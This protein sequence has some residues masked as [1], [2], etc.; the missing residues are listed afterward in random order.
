MIAQIDPEVWLGR[1]KRLDVLREIFIMNIIFFIANCL[2]NYQQVRQCLDDTISEMTNNL[3]KHHT[4]RER[5]Q[6]I[7]SLIRFHK[8]IQKLCN[9]LSSCDEKKITSKPD[10][11]ERAATEFN[12]LNFHFS[13]CQ[14][15]LT[16]EQI[17]VSITVD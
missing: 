10:V 16:K 9:I 4:I 11:L 2:L 13:R 17:S 8:S 3:D 6:S 14:V 15:D 1:I 12:Q 7:H 5:K